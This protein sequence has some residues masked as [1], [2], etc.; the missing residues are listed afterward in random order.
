M[1]DTEMSMKQTWKV[2]AEE[3]K[4]GGMPPDTPRLT[5]PLRASLF[6]ITQVFYH[7]DL[8]IVLQ[9]SCTHH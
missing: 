8:M 5:V 7:Y 3:V 9:N 2:S 4:L 1:G 6:H